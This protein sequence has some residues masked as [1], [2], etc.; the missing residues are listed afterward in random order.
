MRGRKKFLRGRLL[1]LA[2]PR[3]SPVSHNQSSTI[4]K[5]RDKVSMQENRELNMNRDDFKDIHPR[6][7]HAHLNGNNNMKWMLSPH[8]VSHDGLRV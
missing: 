7:G 8:L 3:K 1:C 5:P 6:T 2:D 4:S